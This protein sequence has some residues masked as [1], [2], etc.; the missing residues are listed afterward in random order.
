MTRGCCE[1]VL[2]W[3]AVAGVGLPAAAA[4]PDKVVVPERRRDPYREQWQ[5]PFRI[6]RSTL[7]LARSAAAGEKRGRLAVGG[8]VGRGSWRTEVAPAFEVLAGIFISGART[9]CVRDRKRWGIP[10][11][12]ALAGVFEAAVAAGQPRF[13]PAPV[14][15][16]SDDRYAARLLAGMFDAGDGPTTSTSRSIV[17]ILSIETMPGLRSKEREALLGHRVDV[18]GIAAAASG[19]VARYVGTDI[20]RANR[21]IAIARRVVGQQIEVAP[22]P[23]PV[24]GQS[25]EVLLLAKRVRNCLLRHDIDS[26]AVLV[27]QTREELLG[28][29]GL[30]PKAVGSVEKALL[31]HGPELQLGMLLIGSRDLGYWRVLKQAD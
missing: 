19:E 7:T 30:G 14:R 17:P 10:A 15:D 1:W 13:G 4:T 20:H 27:Q 12:K 9:L 22:R 24:F 8:G 6:A 21:L 11:A 25:I 5:G 28:L 26:I 18:A 29:D 3:V 2:I 16:V 31:G 23:D